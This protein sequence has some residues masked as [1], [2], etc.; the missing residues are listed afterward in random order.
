MTRR[1]SSVNV[2]G[3]RVEHLQHLLALESSKVERL[4]AELEDMTTTIAEAKTYERNLEHMVT[5][6][7]R[8]LEQKTKALE[9]PTPSETN[10]LEVNGS[11]KCPLV[12]LLL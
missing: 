4:S 3:D 10:K 2:L 8:Q 6:L 5:Q 7:S 12:Y 9:I 1:F 11:Y